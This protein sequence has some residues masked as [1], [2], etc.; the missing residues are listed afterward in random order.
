GPIMFFASSR[1]YYFLIVALIGL[2]P[3]FVI[4]LWDKAPAGEKIGRF[5]L[6]LMLGVTAAWSFSN[7]GSSLRMFWARPEPYVLN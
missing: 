1:A 5:F 7:G 6:F 3:Y 4:L 2:I